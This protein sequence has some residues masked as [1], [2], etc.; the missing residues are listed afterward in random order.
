LQHAK[1]VTY[2]VGRDNCVLFVSN[3]ES[4]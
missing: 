4:I 1:G 2:T 3:S